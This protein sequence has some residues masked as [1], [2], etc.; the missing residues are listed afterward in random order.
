[1]GRSRK[2]EK[3]D[4]K[5]SNKRLKS[6]KENTTKRG[7]KKFSDRHPKISLLLKIFIVFILLII[8][9]VS[10]VIAG[11]M[12][13]FFGD[14]F[15]ISQDEL[16][17]SAS[18]SVILDSEGNVIANLSADEKRKIITIGDMADYLP[19]AYVAIEDERFYEHKG[20]DFKRTGGAIFTFILKG[21]SSFG[22]STITQQLVKNITHEKDKSIMRK[23]KEWAKAYQV[24]QMLSKE[25]ILEL[26]LNILFIGADNHGVELG[27]EYYFDTTAKELSLAQCAFLAGIN[28]S[29]NSYNPYDEK[30]DNSEKIKNKTLVVLKKMQ[31]LGF[32]EKEEDYNEAVAQ[33]E[34][35]LE[36]KKAEV[37]GNVYSYHTDAALSQ[38]IKQVAEEKEISEELAKNYVY[39]SGLTIY[40]TLV[41]EIQKT[42]DEEFA[43][44]KYI[45]KSDKGDGTHSQAAMVVIDNNTGYVVGTAGG[46]GEKTESRGLNRATQSTRQTGSATKPIATVVP[47]LQEGIITAAT[48]Y[49]D[50][51]TDFGHNYT[52]KNYNYFRGIISVRDALETS[53]NIPFLK[54]M[55]ELTPQKSI[56]YMEKMGITSLDKERDGLAMCIGGLTYG[57][58][59]LE[60]AGA[61]ETIANDGL[62]T[63]P[64][65]YTKV[66]DINGEVVLKPDQTQRRVM[67]E[68]NAYI[69]KNLLT[70]P[71]V[72]SKGTAKYC[73]IRGMDVGAKTGTTNKNYD[74]WLCGFT[75]YYTAATWYGFDENEE[76]GADNT[77]GRIWAA[78]MSDIHAS[79][80][81]SRF[82]EP[83]GITTAKICS[84]TGQLASGKCGST[85]TEIFVDGTIPEKCEGHTTYNVCIESGQIA[86][87]YCPETEKR[88]YGYT[89]PKERLNLWDNLS[90]TNTG[91]APKGIC[92]IHKKPEEPKPVQDTDAPTITLKGESN[93]TINEGDKYTDPGAT[94]SDKQDGDLTS[95][96][97]ISGKVE[98][99]KPGSYTITYTVSDSAGNTTTKKRTVNVKEKSTSGNTG[100]N[101][102]ENTTT[103][104][105]STEK[106]KTGNK[107][108]N[109]TTE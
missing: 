83:S 85:Y 98:A 56:E 62:Y 69:A 3:K 101:E 105:K 55:A 78:V 92:T 107:V 20:V 48:K 70:E 79:L 60:M 80:E 8:I 57:I 91:N 94:A 103:E 51:K 97:K 39:G 84:A 11:Y 40:T 24:E 46:L 22:G 32:I 81:N 16:K 44:S 49:D 18:N 6:S 86:N 102:K 12:Y 47:G 72:G 52:P 36:F 96:I 14:D 27:A 58:S 21:D 106:E 35:G 31:E 74:K 43:K 41:P 23:V 2:K 68:Q 61:Y 100:K 37:I 50:E 87:E 26:Y 76:V 99:S 42:L 30:T 109:D 66:T 19:K 88:S 73:A 82:E 71:V 33:V 93:V 4:I 63:K 104:N 17:I 25:E 1:M 5:K 67:S 29:P 64:T 65:F 15:E 54:I 45:V 10:G 75:N 38:V 59:P 13:G 90:A 34:A 7:K 89:I 95:K 108:T 9:A 53:Q 77:A 28:S